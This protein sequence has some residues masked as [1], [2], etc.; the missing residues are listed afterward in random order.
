M[1]TQSDAP[2]S[3]GYVPSTDTFGARLALVRQYR[4][5]NV[6]E[7]A[8]ASSIPEAT[9]RTWEEGRSPRNMGKVC[10]SIAKASGVDLFWLA[11]GT[12]GG[13]NLQ[14]LK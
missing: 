1:T 4:K 7:A 12:P 11:F 13:G 2:A 3:G 14:N 8:D 10:E 6:T 9:W 5:W